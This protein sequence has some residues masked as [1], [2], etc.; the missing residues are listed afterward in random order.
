MFNKDA[1]KLSLN[2]DHVIKTLGSIIRIASYLPTIGEVARISGLSRGVTDRALQKLC[3]RGYA[4]FVKSGKNESVHRF[5]L[6]DKGI[7]YAY[8]KGLL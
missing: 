6:E 1:E 3:K 2:D 7:Q 8:E 4:S 5:S